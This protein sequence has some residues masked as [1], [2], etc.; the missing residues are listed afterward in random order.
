M[1][2]KCQCKINSFYNVSMP[3]YVIHICSLTF[4]CSVQ[5]HTT[6][7]E[8]TSQLSPFIIKCVVLATMTEH[9]MHVTKYHM[10]QKKICANIVTE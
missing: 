6:R 10:Y 5:V 8:H 7:L 9:S 3:L 4:K 1:L 2:L